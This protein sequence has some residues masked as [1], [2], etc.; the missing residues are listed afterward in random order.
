MAYIE[1]NQR[2]EFYV[3][4]KAL[5]RAREYLL[6]NEVLPRV[7][8]DMYFEGCVEFLKNGVT[9]FDFKKNDKQIEK[10]I[11]DE[12]DADLNQALENRFYYAIS[13]FNIFLLEN[14]SES[15]SAAKEDVIEIYRY[16]ATNDY[17]LA[18]G[19]AAV[20]FSSKDE[21]EIENSSEVQTEISNQKR[22]LEFAG[23]VDDWRGLRIFG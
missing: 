22:D 9:K 1:D 2:P 5:M 6:S 3:A 7:S 19:G 23:K 15:L 14:E 4:I 20:I 21:E 18:R 17:L 13:T 11:I 8:L 12:Q 10:A 16:K